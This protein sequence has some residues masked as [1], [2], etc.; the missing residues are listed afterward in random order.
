MSSEKGELLV[1]VTEKSQYCIY[2]D[3]VPIEEIIELYEGTGYN[4]WEYRDDEVVHALCRKWIR[5]LKK[6]GRKSMKIEGVED[7]PNYFFYALNWYMIEEDLRYKLTRN[8]ITQEVTLRCKA[9]SQ[10]KATPDKLKRLLNGVVK[11]EMWDVYNSEWC[12]HE[13]TKCSVVWQLA[14]KL[15]TERELKKRVRAKIKAAKFTD[16][17]L[18]IDALMQSMK[19]GVF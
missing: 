13:T 7:E 16:K 5:E 18:D 11:R 9:P 1:G 19:D 8:S 15:M 10:N 12:T 3:S 17:D 2:I 6:S 14:V 4:G